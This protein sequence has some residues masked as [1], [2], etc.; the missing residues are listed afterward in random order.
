MKIELGFCSILTLIF[1]IAKLGGWITWSW[2]LVFLPVIIGFT[3][4][5]LI[6]AF[7]FGIVILAAVFE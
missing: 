3:I 7:I 2:W 1:V 6:L 4:S 5:M